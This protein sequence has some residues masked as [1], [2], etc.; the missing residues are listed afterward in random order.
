MV[1]KPVPREIIEQRI[2]NRI[3]VGEPDECWEWTGPHHP[4]GYAMQGDHRVA[5]FLLGLS[6]GDGLHARHTC[7]NPWCVNPGHLLIGTAHD[8]H[9]DMVER[10]RSARDEKHWNWKGGNSKNYRLGSNRIQSD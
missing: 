2:W 7:D 9:V 6:K 1:G 3:V 8:N 10:G 4:M 5:R